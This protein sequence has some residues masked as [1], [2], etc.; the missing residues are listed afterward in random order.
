MNAD[1]SSIFVSGEYRADLLPGLGLVVLGAL[2]LWDGEENLG[3][4]VFLLVGLWL[5][6]R[7]VRFWQKPYVEL[8]RG[9]LV[10]FE[11]GRLKHYVPLTVIGALERTFNATRLKLR[12]GME[13][14]IG[15]LGFIS[16]AEVERF[17]TELANRMDRPGVAGESG[18]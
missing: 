13:I 9:R 6:V 3:G 14:R 7:G 4:G 16:S 17:R 8:G 2:A 12:D 10:I 15:N 11:R 5:L 18:D 1:S